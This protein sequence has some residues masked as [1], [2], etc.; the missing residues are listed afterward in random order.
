MNIARLLVAAFALLGAGTS[1]AAAE[2]A[3]S[4]SNGFV[5]RHAF[6]VDAAP[7]E[8]YRRFVDIRGW[9]D[10]E[11]TFSGSAANLIL[12]PR[13]GGCWCEKMPDNGFVRHM[14]V[15]Y[16]APGKA[17]RMSGGLG[18]LQTMAV[19]AAADVQFAADGQKTRVTFTYAV[20]G[21]APNGLG[22][23]APVVDGVLANQLVRYRAFAGLRR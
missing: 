5:V 18:P 20:G 23:L 12:S 16:A 11:H 7:Q 10:S 9:W 1:L 3:S 22:E 6:I 14:D 17:L 15:I 13:P 4:A 19:T 21:Y 8:A 2:V